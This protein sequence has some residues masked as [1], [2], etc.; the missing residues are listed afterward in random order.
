MAPPSGSCAIAG[1]IGRALA[2]PSRAAAAILR[3]WSVP[4]FLFVNLLLSCSF[5]RFGYT[6]PV[7]ATEIGVFEVM[8]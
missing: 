3:Y 2:I 1:S 8:L 7:K 5:T 4:F 6:H